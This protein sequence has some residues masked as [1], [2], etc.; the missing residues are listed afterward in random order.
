ML[1]RM[2][3]LTVLTA[4]LAVGGTMYA[5]KASAQDGSP[6]IRNCFAQVTRPANPRYVSFIVYSDA[7]VICSD[8]KSLIQMQHYLWGPDI[9]GVYGSGP[10]AE[11]VKSCQYCNSVGSR[12]TIDDKFGIGQYA[13]GA[14]WGAAGTLSPFTFVWG[15]FVGWYYAYL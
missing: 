14:N 8:Q 11:A 12:L 3:G 7:N 15:P 9:N 1:R 6:G 4:V 13:S 2:I 5:P 10:R